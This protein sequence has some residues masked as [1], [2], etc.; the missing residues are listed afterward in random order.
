MFCLLHKYNSNVVYSSDRIDDANKVLK[1]LK[2]FFSRAHRLL[3]ASSGS[4]AAKGAVWSE[5]SAALVKGVGETRVGV[6]TALADDL[7]TPVVMGLVL[8]QLS[9]T[10]ALLDAHEANGV[11]SGGGGAPPLAG[12]WVAV[13]YVAG[14]CRLFGLDDADTGAFDRLSVA[15]DAS[16]DASGA[17]AGAGVPD[18]VVEEVLKL[19]GVLRSAAMDKAADGLG[20][21]DLWGLC[22]AVRDELLPK[23]GAEVKDH[24]DGTTSWERSE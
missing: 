16:Q 12:L 14:V 20:K 11:S 5:G 9:A 8:Q 10:H 21:K 2:Q 7:D 13:R 19:R 24:R 18:A 22:D 17:G 4:E 6:D 3:H 1:R 23:M 15:T